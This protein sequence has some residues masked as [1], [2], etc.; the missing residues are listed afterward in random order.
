MSKKFSCIGVERQAFEN[1]KAYYTL[2]IMNLII[3]NTKSYEKRDM[4]EN[5]ALTD[6]VEICT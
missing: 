6:S 5:R 4:N 3:D 2:T 1:M